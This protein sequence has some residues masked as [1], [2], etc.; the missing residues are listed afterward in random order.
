MVT[1]SYSAEYG[2]GAGG[3][4]NLITRSG[5]NH[6]HGSTYEY[7]RN[8]VLDARNF[9]DGADK[10]KFIRNQF[11]ATLGGPIQRDK[12]FLFYSY[13]GLRSASSV[14]TLDTV[15]TAAMR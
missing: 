10:P 9:F 1:N 7:L 8:R 15:P 13:E 14:I 6:W 3:Q 11:G 5:S 12:T 2:R 4:I